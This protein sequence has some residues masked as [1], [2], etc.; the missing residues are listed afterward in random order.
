MTKD[1]AE[2]LLWVLQHSETSQASETERILFEKAVKF[3]SKRI[4]IYAKFLGK[5]IREVVKGMSETGSTAGKDTLRKL[6]SCGLLW[7]I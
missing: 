1:F 5:E 3:S 7:L 4:S 6:A 2:D